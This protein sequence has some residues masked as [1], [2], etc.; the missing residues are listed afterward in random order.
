MLRVTELAP[1]LSTL[2]P[3]DMLYLQA[4]SAIVRR[5]YKGAVENYEEIV[6]RLP[7]EEKGSA[8]FD[9]GRAY[10]RAGDTNRAI[11]AFEEVA[12]RDPQAAAALLRLGG[13]YGRKQEEAKSAAAFDNAQK[14]YET[15]NN[16]EG[17][18]EVFYQRGAAFNLFDKLSEA[19]EQF[20]RALDLAM[21]TDN[22]P[23]QIK[24]LLQLGSVSYS[25]GETS[26]AEQYTTQAMELAR[27]EQLD[28]LT[29][30]G[31]VE[32]GNAFFLRGEYGE[33]E[34]YF[35]QSLQIAKAN[36]GGRGEARALLSLGSLFV[37]QSS[38]G[39]GV[40]VSRTGV[41]ILPAGK[42][43]QGDF[44]SAAPARLRQRTARKQRSCTRIL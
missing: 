19:Q 14:L 13:L 20:R 5:N 17:M 7:E 18:A 22:K 28:N 15:Q 30:T 26:R 11:G 35:Q 34:K 39:T 1:N 12:R 16:A 44:T 4:I 8:Y 23:Q 3:M 21:T 24:T 25:S 36:K 40:E 31:L 10:E 2:P 38:G 6:K 43:P 37:Q 42:F 32:I 27:S 33:A 29:T 41:G 9:L